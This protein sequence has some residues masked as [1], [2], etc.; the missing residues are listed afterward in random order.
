M[1]VQVLK[2]NANK[3]KKLFENKVLINPYNYKVNNVGYYLVIYKKGDKLKGYSVISE[4]EYSEADAILAFEQLVGFTALVNNFFE[5]EQAKMKLS[6][7]SF[8][9]ISIVLKKYLATN[10]NDT[11]SK[12]VEV[13]NTLESNLKDLQYQIK[14]YS[15]HYDDKILVS[16]NIDLKEIRKLMEVLS[17]LNR[18]QYL[19][20]SILLDTHE[21]LIEVYKEM[22]KQNLIKELS[23][24]DQTVIK[25]LTTDIKDVEKGVN[26]LKVEAEIVDLPVEEQ[27]EILIGEF[28]KA[29]KEKLPRY[30]QDLRYPKP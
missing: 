25:E 14:R 8:S 21:S 19:Q 17:Q 6:P 5:L 20:G 24:Y 4:K 23:K 29:I 9:N 26:S 13:L 18:I 10:N 1:D 12:G 15:Q 3:H 7:D 2:R 16:N 11:L 30:K 22:K 28:E 27:I